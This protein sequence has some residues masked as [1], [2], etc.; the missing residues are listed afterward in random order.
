MRSVS[1]ALKFSG[2]NV[3]GIFLGGVGEGVGGGVEAGGFDVGTVV[4]AAVV[5]AVVPP[6]LVHAEARTL[7]QTPATID[8][9]S[10]FPRMQGM[11]AA[12]M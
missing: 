11:L 4:G 2:E 9:T 10:R 8:V 1:V 12:G 6:S 3:R 5:G 7:R